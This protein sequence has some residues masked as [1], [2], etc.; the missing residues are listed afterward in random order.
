MQ[1]ARQ[2][3]LLKSGSLVAAGVHRLL[4]G[5]D[6]VELHVVTADDPEASAKIRDLAPGVIV[7]DSGDLCLREGVIP[8]FLGEHPNA[9]VIALSQNHSDIEVYRIERSL[10]T[11]LPGLLEAIRG[12]AG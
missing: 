2:V 3:V 5:V 8:R 1:E 9:E 11:D 12:S 7:L 10:H 6:G 4:Q